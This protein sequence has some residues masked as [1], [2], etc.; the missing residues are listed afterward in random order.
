[1]SYVNMLTLLT[2]ANFPD[3]MLPAYYKN[4]FVMLY[5]ISYLM[6]GLYILMNLL[7]ATVF[8]KFKGR[9]QKR[10]TKN[11]AKRREL[12]LK[13]YNMFDTQGR[14]YLNCEEFKLFTSFVFNIRLHTQVGLDQHKR[15]ILKMG[16]TEV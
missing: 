12:V 16:K 5:F 9:Y 3:I 14:G 1:M 6:I 15:I 7:L 4:Y 10:I 8:N 2:T 11:Y 13:A